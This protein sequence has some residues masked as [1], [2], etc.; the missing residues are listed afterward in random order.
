MLL[1]LFGMCSLE[2]VTIATPARLFGD[3][4]RTVEHFCGA[5]PSFRVL[6]DE[7][8]RPAARSLQ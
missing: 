6:I 8:I 1:R 4:A 7:R 5:T 2:V 3:A